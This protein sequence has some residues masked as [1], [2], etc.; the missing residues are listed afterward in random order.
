VH[1]PLHLQLDEY[2]LGTGIGEIIFSENT[3][4][5]PHLNSIH[6]TTQERITK[7]QTLL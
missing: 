2:Y 1:D 7:R 5:N 4:Y 6:D 3:N